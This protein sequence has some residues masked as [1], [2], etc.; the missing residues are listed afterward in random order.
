MESGFRKFIE[1]TYGIRFLLYKYIFRDNICKT[2]AQHVVFASASK[3]DAEK[4]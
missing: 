3:K 1:T 4:T 2:Q